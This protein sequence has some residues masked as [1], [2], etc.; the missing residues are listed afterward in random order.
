MARE[1]LEPGHFDDLA[2]ARGLKADGSRAQDE[3][4]TARSRGLH[5]GGEYRV[6][7]TYTKGT[8]NKQVK[9]LIEQNTSPMVG[10]P[11]PFA[12]VA[13]VH[14]PVAVV[15]GPLGRVCV[16]LDDQDAADVL[17]RAQQAVTDPDYQKDAV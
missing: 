1:L 16:N 14:Q 15:E 10:A 7:G 13:V 2:R 12:D 5:A 4:N 6:L 8:G 9:V 11:E 3:Q 17:E